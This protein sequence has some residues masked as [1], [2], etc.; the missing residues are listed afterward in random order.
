MKRKLLAA[1]LPPVFLL[2]SCLGVSADIVLN[3]DG[4]GT[5]ALEYR[6]SGFLDSLGKL[7]GNERWNTIPAGKADFERTLDRLPDIKLLSFS[8]KEDGKNLVIS[9]KMEFGSIKG[10]LAFLDASGRRA[11]FSGDAGS[12]SMLLTLSKSAG[13][14]NPGLDKLIGDIS[15]GYL[16]VLGMSF[17]G[18]GSL[19]VLDA[20]GNSLEAIP[21]SSITPRGKKVS[22]SIPIR[23]ILSAPDGIIAGFS[24]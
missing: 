15:E 19:S 10:L 2:C 20:H 7:D 13:S 21:G 8:S 14:N 12:G 6:I 16:A 4:S 23:E 3:R 5:I 18:E 11:S 17:P 1:I 22:L 9:V 24:W